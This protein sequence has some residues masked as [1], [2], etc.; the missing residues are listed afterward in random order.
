MAPRRVTSVTERV[1]PTASPDLE[2]EMLQRFDQLREQ[3]LYQ[4]LGVIATANPDEVRR[5]YYAL[6]KRFHPDKFIREDA[7]AKAEKVFAHITEAYSTLTHPE[8]RKRYDEDQALRKSSREPEKKVD[9]GLVAHINFKHGKDMFDK[10]KLGEA[11]TF[12][13]NACDQDPSKAEHFH[14]LAIAQS[15]NPRWKKDAEENFLKAIEKD[16]MNAEI[17]THLGSLY[18]R[19][20]MHSK[21]RDMFKKALQWDPAQQE[22]SEGLAQL[23]EG[24]KGLLG[25]FKK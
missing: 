6:A 10:G 2:A 17:Y 21:A 3:D 18:A 15:K 4:V 13:Q 11:I 9:P 22:A 25:M 19:G 20:G 23:E 8:T 7:K 14:Y 24:K 5:A 1:R 12:L 16:P